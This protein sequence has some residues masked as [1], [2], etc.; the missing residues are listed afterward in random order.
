[1]VAGGIPNVLVSD[2]IVG[3]PKLL[4]LAALSKQAEWVGVCA[5]HPD[6]VTQLDEAAGAMGAALNVLVEI[7][8]GA[9]RCGVEPGQPAVELAKQIDSATNISFAGLQAYQGRAQH[10]RSY[11]GASG[12]RCWHRSYAKTVEGLKSAGLSARSL[13][14]QERGHFTSKR[15]GG[16]QRIAGWLLRLY[17]CGLR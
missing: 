8:T 12:G 6:N 17:G 3:R 11:A 15:R 10:V 2:Q 5:D 14:G 1:M 4:R 9:E 7:D 13:A 16:S